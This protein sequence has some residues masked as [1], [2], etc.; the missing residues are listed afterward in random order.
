MVILDSTKDISN[1]LPAH[2][3]RADLQSQIA[4]VSTG[5]IPSAQAPHTSKHIDN[6]SIKMRS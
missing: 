6:E 1:I 2:V 5:H 4:Q 3:D